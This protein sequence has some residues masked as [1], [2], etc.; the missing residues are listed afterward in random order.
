M[1]FRHLNSQPCGITKSLRHREMRQ[2]G[3]NRE[4]GRAD[5]QMIKSWGNKAAAQ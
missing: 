3:Q 4:G 5:G 2:C 1:S